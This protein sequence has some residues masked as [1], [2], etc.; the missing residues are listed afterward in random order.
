MILGVCMT[1]YADSDFTIE[2]GALKKY[3]GDAVTATANATW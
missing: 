1:A 3:N 2:N